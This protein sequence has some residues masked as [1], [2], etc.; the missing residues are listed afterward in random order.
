MKLKVIESGLF[1]LDGGAMFGV[2]PRQMW[3]RM[4]AP[5][6]KNMC[7]WSMRCLLVED[8]GRVILFDT[9]MGNKQ[10]E[11]FRSH[12]EPH[13]PDSLVHSIEEAGYSIEDITDVFQTHFHFDHVG[14]ALTHDANGNIIPQFPNATYW[15]NEKHYQWSVNPNPREKASFLTENIVPMKEHGVLKNIDVEDGVKFT[16]NITV[17]FYYGHTEA[18]MVPTIQLPNGRKLV[19]T[20]DLLPSAHHVR[21]PYIMAYDVRPLETIRDKHRFYEKALDDNTY[22]FFEHDKDT[23]LGQ[24]IKDAKGRYAIQPADFDKL[25]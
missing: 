22:I 6:E 14:G 15:T 23:V 17:D 20:A 11:K 4:N 9:G 10:G 1:K 19:F 13:G 24:L 7:S 2:V 5:D 16:D 25:I 21:I 8:Q 12:F 3:E 18:M